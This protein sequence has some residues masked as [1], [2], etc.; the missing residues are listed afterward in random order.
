MSNNNSMQQKNN[1]NN[2]NAWNNRWLIG[3]KLLSLANG[4]VLRIVAVEIIFVHNLGCS[5]NGK[6]T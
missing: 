2:E 3:G 6:R 1:N 5:I 4:F